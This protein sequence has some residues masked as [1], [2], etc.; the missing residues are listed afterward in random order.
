MICKFT[1]EK[2]ID[3]TYL[4]TCARCGRNMR[5]VAARVVR[6]CADNTDFGETLPKS[7]LS[8]APVAKPCAMLG[9]A[10]GEIVN[11]VTCSNGTRVKLF[12]CALH[13]KATVGKPIVDV[14][15]CETCSDFT[16]QLFD[17]CFVISLSRRTD[18]LERFFQSVSSAAWP[19]PKPELWP[20][21][22]GK[23]C[24]P[25]KWFK[26]GGGAWGC[27]RS[28]LRLIEHCLT[29]GINSVLVF[30]DDA[31]PVHNVAKSWPS[32]VRSLPRD[33]EQI[34]LG[35]QHLRSRSHA[36]R[37]INDFWSKPWNVNRTHAFAMRGE[38]LLKIYRNLADT[39]NW[40]AKEHVDHRLGRMH[41]DTGSSS[42][43]LIVYNCTQW[44]FGQ[45]EGRSDINGRAEEYRQWALQGV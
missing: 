11:C 34:Y 10:T 2:Q 4:H 37:K 24:S 31:M 16:R 22:D 35:G 38:G 44:L 8:A 25:P 26:A 19:F 23:I 41:S 43:G 1:V 39:S 20:A 30:E 15:C 29:E 33:W 32:Y 13:G 9:D 42:A 17:K 27:Y 28:H 12:N 21:T 6:R 45:A 40:K 14:A 3:G 36:P 5:S 7:V 18:R